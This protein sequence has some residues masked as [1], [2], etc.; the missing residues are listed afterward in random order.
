MIGVLGAV[1]EL[2]HAFSRKDRLSQPND[3]G[4]ARVVRLL[5]D[6]VFGKRITILSE[7]GRI[8]ENDPYLV[9]LSFTH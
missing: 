2:R 6:S 1:G 4:T 5:R 8:A 7:S 3:G 9:G